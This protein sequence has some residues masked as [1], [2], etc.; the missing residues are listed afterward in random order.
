MSASVSFWNSNL[1]NVMEGRS[2]IY[3]LVGRGFAPVDSPSYPGFQLQ[4]HE[5]G[6]NAFLDYQLIAPGLT[7]P[8]AC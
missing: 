4:I 6:P 5:I 7:L 3:P 1:Y 2:R 8:S